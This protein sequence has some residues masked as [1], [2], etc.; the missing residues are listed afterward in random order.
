MA[1]MNRISESTMFQT[2][3]EVSGQEYVCMGEGA[4]NG[5]MIEMSQIP[6]IELPDTGKFLEVIQY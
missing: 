5:I 1:L 2:G 6:E 3:E 4:R